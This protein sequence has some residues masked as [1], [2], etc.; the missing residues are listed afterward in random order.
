MKAWAT[1]LIRT[2]P[3][4][5]HYF[6]SE[7]KTILNGLLDYAVDKELIESNK[8]RGIKIN[9]RVFKAKDIKEDTEDV[10]TL[11]EEQ[12]IMAEA[13]KELRKPYKIK[14]PQHLLHV[15]ERIRTPDTLVRSQVLYPAELRTH[16]L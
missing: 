2:H 7:I 11:E 8:F 1:D 16:I 15:R 3:M 4:T 13:E 10:F 5:K 9:S 14:F 6:S 12:L